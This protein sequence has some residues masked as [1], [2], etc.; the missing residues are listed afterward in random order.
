MRLAKLLL[1]ML[2]PT[3]A[4]AAACPTGYSNRAEFVVPYQSLASTLTSFP[5]LL[6]FNGITTSLDGLPTTTWF[7]VPGLKTNVLSSGNDIVFCDAATSGNLL[8]FERVFWTSTTG[9]SEFYVSRTLSN[10]A[11]T[12]IW[13]FWGKTSDSDHSSAAAVWSAA[14]YAY[15]NHF[16]TNGSLSVADS[17]GNYTPINHS[18]VTVAGVVGGGISLATSQYVDSGASVGT[19]AGNITVEFWLN[20]ENT[21]QAAS[22]VD[23]LDGSLVGYNTNFTNTSGGSLN[24]SY[25]VGVPGNINN[26]NATIPFGPP[27]THVS[28]TTQ[29]TSN[30]LYLN[31]VSAATFTHAL[32]AGSSNLSVGR[33]TGGNNS[34]CTACYVDEVRVSRTTAQ[35]ADWENAVHTTIATPNGF[36]IMLDASTPAGMTSGAY[37]V[38]VTV[39]HAQIPNTD[40]SNFP[41]LVFGTYGWMADTTHNGFAVNGN[42]GHDIRFYSNS[43]CTSSLAFQRVYWTNTTG[44]SSWR[45]R[46]PT[47]SHTSDTTV[48]VKIGSSADTSDLSTLWMGTY[49]YIGVFN[50]GSPASLSSSD[51]GSGNLGLGCDA[52][53]QSIYSP[54][55]GGF[56][57]PAGGYSC[58]YA[59]STTGENIGQYGYP[60][61]SAVG[62]IRIWAKTI[63]ATNSG[64]GVNFVGYGKANN[65][66]QRGFQTEY[67]DSAQYTGM[68]TLTF[69]SN[70]AVTFTQ[71]T[72]NVSTPSFYLDNNWHLYDFDYPTAA[73]QLSTSSLYIDG[74]L[75]SP[76]Y[77]YAGANT[78]VLNT[79]NGACTA[80]GSCGTDVAEVRIG[81]TAAHGIDYFVG[82]AAQ[83]EVTNVSE[84]SDMVNA[85]YNNERFPNTFYSFGTASPLSSAQPIVTVIF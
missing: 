66:G 58:G 22:V 48:Y 80:T 50:G 59:P 20:P 34:F 51:S 14:N 77:Y 39:A 8:N 56:Y 57:F 63:A 12:A 79:D 4:W 23:D 68:Q 27:W 60:V 17:A 5:V 47:L 78:T 21:S 45:V 1:V 33:Y 6:A 73:G 46:V 44:E 62:H 26:T 25:Q 81:R 24:L 85:R 38:P 53:V 49:N 29:G 42:A 3:M 84:S 61:G 13:M 43:G 15:V 36:A 64:A 18:G 31:G 10:S 75:A 67:S 11:N 52:Q 35:S 2:C 76:P 37:C 83:F 65:N 82:L 9:A 32:A 71:S 19:L 30:V 28:G 72:T 40:Q 41:L 69:P 74:V 16:G 54:V 55:G 70:P 7:N